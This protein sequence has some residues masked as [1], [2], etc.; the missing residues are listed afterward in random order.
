MQFS[1]SQHVP[2]F[3]NAVGTR[4]CAAL[5]ILQNILE[6]TAVQ[7]EATISCEGDGRGVTEDEQCAALK[8][9]EVRNRHD[10]RAKLIRYSSMCQ[11]RTPESSDRYFPL[12]YS[13]I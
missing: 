4:C 8:V 1:L 12:T 6:Q 13:D 9:L 10:K 7:R 3:V 5:Q 2:S 11:P